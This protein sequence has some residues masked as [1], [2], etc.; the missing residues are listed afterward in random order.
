V[1]GVL[2]GSNVTAAKSEFTNQIQAIGGNS[3]L[4]AATIGNFAELVSVLVQNPSDAQKTVISTKL[5]TFLTEGIKFLKSQPGLENVTTDPDIIN[6]PQFASFLN[7]YNQF[8]K[9]L[10][11][12]QVNPAGSYDY[13]SNIAD[14]YAGFA[15]LMVQTSKTVQAKKA[16]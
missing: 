6:D 1:S 5:A 13:F 2:K 8:I 7:S 14:A 3:E 11:D 4:A 9:I 16:G 12:L 10:Q 15:V